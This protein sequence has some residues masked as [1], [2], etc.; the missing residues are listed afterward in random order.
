M[1]LSKELKEYI[2]L[3]HVFLVIAISM[4]YYLSFRNTCV[5]VEWIV[6]KL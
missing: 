4:L 6:L 2:L 5:Q 3:V 1:F